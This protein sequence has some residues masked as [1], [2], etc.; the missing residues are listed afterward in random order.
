MNQL[1]TSSDITVLGLGSMGA[2][3][4]H[5]L[6]NT[7]LKVTVWNRTAARAEPLVRRGASFASSAA[8]AIAQSP[9]TVV[10]MLDTAAF[11]A[12]LQNDDVRAALSGKTLANLSTGT[13]D[14]ARRIAA[15][16]HRL[17]EKYL[18]GGILGYP[19]D[20]GAA[21]TLILYAGSREAFE[22]HSTTLRAMAGSQR[23]LSEDAGG[24]ITVYF[25][26]CDYYFGSVT[27]YL[28]AA[29]LSSTAGMDI[30]EFHSIAKQLD[31]WLESGISD[32]SRRIATEKLSGEQ[33]SIDVHLAGLETI[34]SAFDD[35]GVSCYSVDA[36][37]AY[38]MEC[39]AAGLGHA[40]I[41]SIFGIM[42]K[43][44]PQLAMPSQPAFAA[45]PCA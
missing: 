21:G 4:A 19:R 9:L 40:D 6:V 42:K 2:A 36:F 8:A 17:N 35:A 7:G 16:V 25:A 20:I 18:H 30:N 13:I 29:A 43:L 41:A 37:I 14:E 5:S 28:E 12:V 10:C 24:A 26:L 33:A 22:G 31:P 39:Q 45:K 44:P 38:L 11:D 15:V 23:F 3:L 32:V 1:F 34:K 27:A